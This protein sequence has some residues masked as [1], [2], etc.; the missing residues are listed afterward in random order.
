GPIHVA[1]AVMLATAATHPQLWAASLWLYPKLGYAPTV[2]LTESVV[3][4]VE[5]CVIGWWAKL[6]AGQSV[7]VSAIANT[8]SALVGLILMDASSSR[9]CQ[10]DESHLDP[11]VNR[12]GNA[13]DRARRPELLIE[14]IEGE[15]RDDSN[16]RRKY[17]PAR[18]SHEPARHGITARQQERQHHNHG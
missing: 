14:A 16:E 3:I 12:G 11:G 13:V 17:P 15:T 10:H 8:S 1:L 18:P 9:Q 7:L 6:P 4:L 5:A 2:F